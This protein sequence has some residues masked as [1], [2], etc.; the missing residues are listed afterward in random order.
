MFSD[1]L[2]LIHLFKTCDHYGLSSDQ[3]SGKYGEGEFL[4]VRLLLFC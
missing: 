1:D 2:T 4:G 3:F